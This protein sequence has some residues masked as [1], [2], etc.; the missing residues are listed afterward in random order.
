MV[1]MSSLGKPRPSF[2]TYPQA[3]AAVPDIVVFYLRHLVWPRNLCMMYDHD[4]QVHFGARFFLP[5]LLLAAIGSVLYLLVRRGLLDRSLAIIGSALLL[6]PLAPVL[7]IRWFLNGDY[8]HDR[9]LYLPSAGLALLA[10][11]VVVPL[12]ERAHLPERVFG[13]SLPAFAAAAFACALLFVGC[14]DEVRPYTNELTLWA[15]AAEYAPNQIRNLWSLALQ[16]HL[17]HQ[18]EQAEALLLRANKIAPD[19]PDPLQLLGAIALDRH[20]YVH[21]EALFARVLQ[22]APETQTTYFEYGNALLGQHRAA[23]AEK[24]FR[25]GVSLGRARGGHASIA[26]ALEE[27]GKNAEA[28]QEFREELALFPDN[29]DAQQAFAQLDARM[30]AAAR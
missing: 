27:Q 23:E 5:V 8:L 19:A 22:L 11:A 2:F 7:N 14:I 6:F 4:Y 15:R 16:L 24:I 26:I 3:L 30:H 10:A 28:L 20:D 21:A 25:Y 12:F 18:D 1:A 13:Y 17:R 29:Q 9:Y